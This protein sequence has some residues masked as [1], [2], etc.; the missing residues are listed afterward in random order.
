MDD[1]PPARGRVRLHVVRQDRGPGVLVQERSG[2]L[3]EHHADVEVQLA[4]LL[5]DVGPRVDDDEEVLAVGGADAV[6]QRLVGR[7]SASLGAPPVDRLVQ[8]HALADI[9]V[10]GLRLGDLPDDVVRRVLVHV[11]H[12][13]AP[14]VA[15][16]ER[17]GE[18]LG[19]DVE[20]GPAS[21]G[22]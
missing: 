14:G 4:H 2:V 22:R 17:G 13:V 21:A 5:G 1:G 7:D 18:V 19:L 15:I 6:D 12:I 9:L 11:R 8:K 20:H 10:L 3:L 16:R